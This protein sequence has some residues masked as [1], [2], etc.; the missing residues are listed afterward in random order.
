MWDRIR[1]E[2]AATEATL[3]RL[4]P[5]DIRNNAEGINAHGENDGRGAASAPW[6]SDEGTA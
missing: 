6:A 5:E 4:I 2:S 3:A 1:R